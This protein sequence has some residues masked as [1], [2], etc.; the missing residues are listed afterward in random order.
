[1]TS[2]QG[3]SNN[4]VKGPN[5]PSRNAGGGGGLPGA[6]P[7][8]GC[9]VVDEVLA[10]FRRHLARVPVDLRQAIGGSLSGR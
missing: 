7:F 2:P 5:E 1:M 8:A 10:G 6:Q 4:T 9:F 3:P